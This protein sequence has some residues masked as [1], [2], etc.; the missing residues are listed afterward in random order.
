MTHRLGRSMYDMDPL[1]AA[2]DAWYAAIL[3]RLKAAGLDAAFDDEPDGE[4]DDAAER[5][6]W[7][8]CG[9]PLTHDLRG[10]VQLVATPVYRAEGCEGTDYRSAIVVR[11]EERGRDLRALGGRIAAVN[12]MD[13]QSGMNALRHAAA[14]HTRDGEFFEQV[15]LTGTHAASA[16]AV[17]DGAADVA[18]IDCVTWALLRAHDSYTVDGL[19]VLGWT[20]PAPGLPWVAPLGTD[21]ERLATLRE[22]LAAPAPPELLIERFEVLA[23]DAYDVILAQEQQAIDQGYPE[24]Q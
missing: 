4:T 2:F 13:S 22:A 14:P 9:Y 15:L 11:E 5:L 20:E 19:R 8:T 10:T 17:R 18:A 24:L 3:E 12:A 6:L 1:R 21:A 16:A 23:A 7:Q